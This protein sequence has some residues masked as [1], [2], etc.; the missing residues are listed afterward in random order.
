M[1][2]SKHL[3]RMVRSR[4]AMTGESYATALR[5]VRRHRQEPTMPTDAAPTEEVIASCSFCGKPSTAVERLVAGPSAFI[6]NECVGLAAEIVAASAAATP[7]ESQRSW[8]HF[9][10]R[11]T[12]DIL[13][14]LPALDRQAARA[15]EDLARWVGRLRERG[16]DWTVIA[17]ALGTT[18]EAARRRVEM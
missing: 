12:D 15:E 16:T 13:A 5:T 14:L 18:V 10:D 2:R 11:P 4:A 8:A 17:G 9:A 6:C 1:T 7:G 3:K